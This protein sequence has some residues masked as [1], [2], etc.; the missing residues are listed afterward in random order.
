MTDRPAYLVTGAAGNLGRATV[1]ALAA[2][3]ARVAA[4]DRDAAALDALL[5]GLP[6]E[7]G[8]VALPGADLSDPASCAALAGAAR[9]AL[10]RLDGAAHTVG[11]FA[12]A[13]AAEGEP[14]LWEGMFRLNLMTTVHLFRAV[15]PLLRAGGGGS[16]VATA[17]GAGLR[18][19]AQLGAY[20]ASKAGV[21]RLVEAFAD[22]LKGEGVRVNAVLPGTMDTP[23][24]RAAMP[25]ADPA[26]WVRPAEIAAVIAFLLSPAASG[27]TGAGLPVTGRG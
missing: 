14:A 2:Q 26:L 18:S 11:G 27:V 13:P 25:D 23:Q 17:A 9:A 7:G 3:G 19:P 15:L 1:A 5:A 24:N 4:A 8:H 12:M 6:G 10:G 22:E 21:Q 16:L 20:A